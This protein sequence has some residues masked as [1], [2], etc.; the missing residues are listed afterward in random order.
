MCAVSEEVWTK[1]GPADAAP[2]LAKPGGPPARHASPRASYNPSPRHLWTIQLQQA[3]LRREA[4]RSQALNM[5]YISLFFL[6]FLS[7][8]STTDRVLLWSVVCSPH[9]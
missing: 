2:D 4:K 6:F 9:S 5:N 3:E 8:L 7:I 1:L